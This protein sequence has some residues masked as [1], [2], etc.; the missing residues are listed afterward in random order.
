MDIHSTVV[1]TQ[2]GVLALL[3]SGTEMSIGLGEELHH[4]VRSLSHPNALGRHANL[5]PNIS[6]S[7]IS[8]RYCLIF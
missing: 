2:L 3:T 1:E 7:D 6:I 8:L 4:R 5:P